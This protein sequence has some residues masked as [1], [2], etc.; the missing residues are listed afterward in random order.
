MLEFTND[1]NGHRTYYPLACA[2]S[3]EITLIEMT[4]CNPDY[5]QA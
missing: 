4:M 5:P 1:E 3:E 2:I